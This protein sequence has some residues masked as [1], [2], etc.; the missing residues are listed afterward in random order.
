MNK[1]LHVIV[2]WQTRK[3]SFPG[4]DDN[5]LTIKKN[6]WLSSF[7]STFSI[8]VMTLLALVLAIPAI[9]EYGLVLIALSLPVIFGLP[10]SGRKY[11]LLLF[12]V[13]L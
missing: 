9:V 8:A 2:V 1:I 7:A 6:I 12:P 11:H 10:H 5:T 4:I 3:L 13:Q